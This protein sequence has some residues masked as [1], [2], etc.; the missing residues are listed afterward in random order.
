LVYTRGSQIQ[1]LASDG[2][3]VYYA[4]SH[5]GLIGRVSELAGPPSAV[6]NGL[7]SQLIEPK[8]TVDADRVYFT[9]YTDLQTGEH[10]ILSAPK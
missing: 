3:S 9:A 4:E 1:A 7:G 5:A 10:A 6:V 2:Q 8:I